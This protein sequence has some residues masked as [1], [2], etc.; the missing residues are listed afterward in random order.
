MLEQML[1]PKKHDISE[2]S[3]YEVVTL[4]HLTYKEPINTLKS[5][6]HLNSAINCISNN[7]IKPLLKHKKQWLYIC[8]M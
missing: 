8:L 6:Y 3:N 5:M 7:T 1:P 4:R 2:E